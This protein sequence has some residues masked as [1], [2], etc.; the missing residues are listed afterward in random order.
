MNGKGC[1]KNKNEPRMKQ[2]KFKKLDEINQLK[3][4]IEITPA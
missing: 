3:N 1:K 2:V 4:E